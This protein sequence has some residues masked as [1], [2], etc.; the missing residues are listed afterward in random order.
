MQRYNALLLLFYWGY[1]NFYPGPIDAGPRMILLSQEASPAETPNHKQSA[2]RKW[3][4]Y[5][6][7]MGELRDED[8]VHLG[9]THFK[10]SGSNLTVLYEHFASSAKAKDYF[11]KQLGKAAKIIERKD[12]LDA[13]GKVVG[14]RSEILLRINAEK[15]IPAVLWTDGVKF[16]EI[17]SPTR[18][19]ILKLEK[20]YKY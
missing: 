9:Y 18:E 17:Y 10:A 14:E 12:K 3:E 1:F 11:A 2:Q 15:T 19:S 5:P 20:V 4:F 8:G 13:E 7:S 6:T 16:H